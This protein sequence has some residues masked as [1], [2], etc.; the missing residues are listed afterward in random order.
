PGF[1][2]QPPSSGTGAKLGL[3]GALRPV[4]SKSDDWPDTA[5][6]PF[7]SALLEILNTPWKIANG[8]GAGQDPIVAPP[9]YGCWQAAVPQ[10][11]VNNPPSPPPTWPPTFWL[12]ELNLD[13]RNRVAAAA[14][15]QVVQEQQ[16][17][18]MASAWEQLGETHGAAAR[19][20]QSAVCAIRRG[21]GWLVDHAFQSSQHSGRS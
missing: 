19:G 5:R 12:N 20:D 14:G 11:G 7:Q 10:V 21:G 17:R 2:L 18:L 4:R 9:R 8:S 15:T 16:E 3:E 1:K 13:P 6:L